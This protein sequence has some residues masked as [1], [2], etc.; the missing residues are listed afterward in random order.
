MSPLGSLDSPP[1][2]QK[3]STFQLAFALL[4]SQQFNVP[5]WRVFYQEPM[6]D[7]SEEA[8]LAQTLGIQVLRGENDIELTRI[9]PQIAAVNDGVGMTVVYMLGRG[10]QWLLDGGD[11][12]MKRGLQLGS[13]CTTIF[14]L[15]TSAQIPSIDWYSSATV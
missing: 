5:A 15:L 9:P 14:S 12:V 1:I 2:Y 11:W 3:I 13:V 7:A 4:L 10:S 6:A 8:F